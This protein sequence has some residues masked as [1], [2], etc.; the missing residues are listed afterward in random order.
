MSGSLDI[1]A[2]PALGTCGW[3]EDGFARR[4]SVSSGSNLVMSTPETHGCITKGIGVSK[5]REKTLAM[6]REWAGRRRLTSEF[7]LC[8]RVCIGA[9]EIAAPFSSL[10][11]WASRESCAGVTPELPATAPDRQRTRQCAVCAAL[12]W[13]PALL[14]A[15]PLVEASANTAPT[16]YRDSA[17]GPF[18]SAGRDMA[19]CPSFPSREHG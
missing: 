17:A 12:S 18:H 4:A 14:S 10:R 6:A 5:S 9:G 2:G 19:C 1:S 11:F 15:L 16:A 13:L 7:F 8:L 3:Q